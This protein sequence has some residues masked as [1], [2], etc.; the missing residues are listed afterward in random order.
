MAKDPLVEDDVEIQRL[1][2][3]QF[4]GEM[5]RGQLAWY[6]VL[7]GVC[8]TIARTVFRASVRGAENVPKEG[9]FI[10]C[11][12]HRSY[13]DTPAVSLVTSRRLRYMGKASM[14]KS[15]FGAW[16]L[17]G[18]GGFPVK[19]GYIDREAFDACLAVLSRGE[20]LVLFPEGT[21]QEGPVVEGFHDGAAYLALKTGAPIVPVGLG[22]MAAAMGPGAKV[23]T[24]AKMTLVVGEPIRPDRL[25]EGGR[26]SLKAR[27]AL[28]AELTARVQALYDEAQAWAGHP[29]IY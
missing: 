25:P 19:R 5:S 3:H 2:Q 23:P 13:L 11:A 28:T 18:A 6:K 12:V 10:L 26:V 8:I 17:T 16:F 7:R 22:G 27:R 14:W 15:K 1:G 20:P 4:G 9:P 29:N 21:R 24:L